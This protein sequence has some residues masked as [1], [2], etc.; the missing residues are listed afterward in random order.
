MINSKPGMSFIK[1]FDLYIFRG[2]WWWVSVTLPLSLESDLSLPRAPC[3]ADHS[4]SLSTTEWERNLG[5]LSFPRIP[6]KLRRKKHPLYY[7]TRSGIFRIELLILSLNFRTLPYLV[8]KLWIFVLCI[9]LSISVFTPHF[10]L[11][12]NFKFAYFGLHGAYSSHILWP[13]II[14]LL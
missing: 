14:I 9:F 4:S 10:C 11:Y 5:S 2:H 3:S 12:L 13:L 6:V 8:T 7:V 1:G